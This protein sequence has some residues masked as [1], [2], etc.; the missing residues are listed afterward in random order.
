MIKGGTRDRGRESEAIPGAGEPLFDPF[1]PVL[2]TDNFFP[3]FSFWGGVVEEG[4]AEGERG[5][6]SRLRVIMY[7]ALQRGNTT[8]SASILYSGTSCSGHLETKTCG[9]AV[10]K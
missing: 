4:E 10:L 9:V 1:P 2:T 3:V 5:V 7:E 8:Q 6:D